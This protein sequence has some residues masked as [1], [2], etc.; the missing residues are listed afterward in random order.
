M[1]HTS[2]HDPEF[3]KGVTMLT[4]LFYSIFQES[5]TPRTVEEKKP[6]LRLKYFTHV[7]I[8]AKFIIFHICLDHLL[9]IDVNLKVFL[10][11]SGGGTS[12]F[13]KRDQRAMPN[14]F[15]FQLINIMIE[16]MG[17]CLT[18]FGSAAL[19][20]KTEQFPLQRSRHPEITEFI[21]RK[22]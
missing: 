22:S 21:K 13:V 17:V 5:K 2:P 19:K 4:N 14:K 8:R 20:K 10:L 1:P 15:T 12:L 9:I 3:F 7:N 11:R 6:I 18:C 16:P